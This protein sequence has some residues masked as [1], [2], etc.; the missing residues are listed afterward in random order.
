MKSY[1]VYMLLCF[2]GSYYT[3]FTNNLERRL[4]EHE[5]GL[6]P[7]SYTYLR[8]PVKLVWYE[9]F[10]QV[11]QAIEFEKQLKKW[12]RRKKQ[13]LIDNDWERIVLYS[14]NYTQ[15]GKHGDGLSK[16]ENSFD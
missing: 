15:F 5:Y 9:V 14:K 4:Q 10:S 13:A 11:N 2:D 6:N 8:R 12:S 1:Y 3:G 7:D 16:N